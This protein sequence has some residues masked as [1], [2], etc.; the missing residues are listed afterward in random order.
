LPHPSPSLSPWSENWGP[1][2]SCPATGDS[3][4]FDAEARTVTLNAKTAL[5]LRAESGTVTIEAPQVTVEA[6]QVSIEGTQVTLEAKA[7]LTLRAGAT[8]NL[9]AP[10]TTI[11]G[12]PVSP[13]GPPI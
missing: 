7:A 2:Y 10:A 8:M 13:A 9:Q 1:P 6:P 11:A 4:T 3:L 12:R 5:K